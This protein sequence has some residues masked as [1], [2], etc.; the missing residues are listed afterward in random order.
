MKMAKHLQFVALVGA[1]ALALPAAAQQL[2]LMTGPQGGSWVPLGGALKHMWE[3]AIPGLQ[4]QATPGAGIANVRG[5]DEGKAQV[6]FANSSTTVDGIAGRKPYPKK[7][8]K[9]CQVANLYPQYFQV[10]ALADSGINS[11]ADLKGKSLVTQPKGNTA[12]I[13]TEMVLRLN[14]LS[15]QQLAKGNANFQ[16]SYTDAVAMMK[17]GHAQVMTLGTTA[18]ASA[19]M[20]L[21]SAR[22]MKLVPVDDKTMAAL[23]KENAG[24]NKLI[25]KA[26]TYPKQDKDVPVIGYS[27]HIVA[28]CDLPEDTVY[29]MT[30]AMAQNVDAMAAVVKPITGLTPKDMAVDIGV[31]FHKGAAKFYKEVGAL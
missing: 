12:E 14:G 26:G 29:K 28:A 2:T 25:I 27:T 24:Y 30:K 18:P 5:V 3:Q 11:Y 1:V 8:T 17:D 13:L 31:P 15:Y 20:D 16:G 23:K 19:V 6:G 9:V 22:D 7:V 4:V 10:A 21:A